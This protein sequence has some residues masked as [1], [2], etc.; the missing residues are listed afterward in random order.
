MSS[1]PHTDNPEIPKIPGHEP[2]EK[3]DLPPE[4]PLPGLPG[5][6]LGDPAPEIAPDAP[7]EIP[8]IQRNEVDV[9]PLPTPDR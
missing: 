5:R 2:M 3:P 7:M 8:D 6:E 9:P 4:V 1:I